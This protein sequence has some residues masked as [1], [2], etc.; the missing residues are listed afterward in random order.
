MVQISSNTRRFG[1]NYTPLDASCSIVSFGGIPSR[2]VHNSRDGGFAPDY[3]LTPLCLFPRCNASSATSDAVSDDV[4]DK[5]NS[6]AWYELV[7][8]SSSK[9]YVRGNKITT[10]SDYEVI[11]DSPGN[12]KKGMLKVKKNSATNQPIRL[13][14][15]AYYTNTKSR[16]IIHFLGQYTVFCDDTEKPVPTLH[17]SP[18]VISFNPLEDGGNITFEAML[19]DGEN[20]VTDSKNS[21][22]FWYRKTNIQNDKYSLELITGSAEKDFDVVQLTTKTATVDGK[23]T[24]VYGSKLT[25]NKDMVGEGEYYVCRAMYRVDGLS[26]S[27]TLRD[28]DPIEELAVLRRMP[29]YIVSYE[30]IGDSDDENISSINPVAKVSYRNTVVENPEEFFKFT[31]YRK[32]P[33]EEAFKAVATG[34]APTISFVDGMQIYVVAEDKGPYKLIVDDNGNYLVSD[35]GSYLYDK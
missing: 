11:E 31:W 3:R 1:I 34:I 22:F 20:D 33:G 23:D 13:E 9:K 25:I 29:A 30:C 12:L 28:Y 18:S 8:N 7:Y 32:N 10:G 14:F 6:V 17:V 2:Q 19:C 21:R 16:Q 4:N 26:A 24:T 35:D 27:D 5:L 15:E